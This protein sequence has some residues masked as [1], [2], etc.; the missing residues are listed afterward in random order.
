M[1]RSL[2][3]FSLGWLES[4]I[5]L[6]FMGGILGVFWKMKNSSP[7][8]Q[9]NTTTSISAK[10][11]TNTS[12]ELAASDVITDTI[13]LTGSNTRDINSAPVSDG[14]SS[15][16]EVNAKTANINTR[17]VQ[18]G[19]SRGD[20]ENIIATEDENGN[21]VVN[22]HSATTAA[23]EKQKAEEAASLDNLLTDASTEKTPNKN[24]PSNV[25]AMP[26]APSKPATTTNTRQMSPTSTSGSH[27]LIAGSS[28]TLADA[29]KQADNLKAQG[30]NATVLP[31]NAG[32]YRISVFHSSDRKKVEEYKAKKGLMSA[33]IFE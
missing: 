9:A 13:A 16:E 18:T 28:K 4:L 7:E 32:V 10:D 20:I 6:L 8:T 2:I 31:A 26:K 29:Q 33:W 23:A 30:L 22:T 15:L 21:L 19:T 24:K 27:H 11:S 14:L 1:S 3:P 25:R 5:I 17:E 12:Q